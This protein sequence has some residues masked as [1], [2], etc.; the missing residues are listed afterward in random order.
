MRWS[1]FIL[2]VAVLGCASGQEA[3]DAAD[4]GPVAPPPDAEPGVSCADAPCFTDVDCLDTSDGFECGACPTGTEGDGVQC[5]DIDACLDSPCFAGVQCADRAA[6]DLGFDCGGC[7]SGMEG[8]GLQCTDIDGCVASP[9]ATGVSCLDIAAPGTGYA[10]G[11]CPTGTTGNGESCLE[12]DECDP[13]PCYPT[14]ACTDTLSPGTGYTCGPCPSGYSGDGESCALSCEPKLALGCGSSLASSTTDTGSRDVV[15]DWACAPVSLT[16]REIVFTF[17]PQSSGIA[18]AALSGLSEDLDL[19]VVEDAGGL[20]NPEDSLS[21][22]AGGFSGAAGTNDELVRWDATAG[23]TYHIVVDGYGDAT[24]SFVLQLGTVVGDVLLSQI[25]SDSIDFVEVRNHG[26]CAVDLSDY[27]LLHGPSCEPAFDFT[28]PQV[29]LPAQSAYRAIENGFPLLA[30]ETSFGASVCDLADDIGFT[31]LCLGTCNT[32]TCSNVI[33]YV[34]R[35]GNGSD[36]IG[37]G[38]PPCV[39]F[40]PGPVDVSAVTAGDESSL[41]RADF[42]GAP[43]SFERADWFIGL[44]TRN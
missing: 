31:A 2:V 7:P 14:V 18:A 20:C 35:D 33:D 42:Q 38:G 30:N 34:E 36:G 4:A 25:S 17:T 29:T 10:C 44:G 23:M 27:S 6:P 5:T 21:C 9:C 43:T 1:A 12:I 37:P 13:N 19:L 11:S 40:S 8:D 39:T 41:R 26:A 22:V 16:G 32:S 28:F 15:D 24:S 3:S